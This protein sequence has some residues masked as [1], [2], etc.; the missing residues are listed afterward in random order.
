MDLLKQIIEHPVDPD[1]AVVA[2]RVPDPHRR[3][4][5]RSRV[6]F[7]LAVLLIG[8]LF[9]V[10]GLQT[11][12]S[13]P[14]I[15]NERSELVSRIKAAQAHRDQLREQADRLAA[16]NARLRNAGL[17]DT[18][19]DRALRARLADLE[20]RTGAAAVTGPGLQITVDD[21]TG[22]GGANR[23]LDIDLQVLLNG[24]WAAGAEAVVR[25]SPSTI[26]R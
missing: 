10:A 25:R 22:G 21:G 7:G 13:R 8:A 5:R 17:G 3:S 16:D 26:A 14:L 2:A 19:E 24:L 4:S 1:Y 6:A 23:V 20:A 9:A 12:R 15:E 18:A 11:T